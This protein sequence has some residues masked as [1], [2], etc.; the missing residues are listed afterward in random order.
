MF[1]QLLHKRLVKWTSKLFIIV[2]YPGSEIRISISIFTYIKGKV[3]YTQFYKIM[4]YVIN[5]GT[6][7]SFKR[8]SKVQKIIILRFPAFPQKTVIIPVTWNY[9][10]SVN[11]VNLVCATTTTALTKA[12]ENQWLAS[13]QLVS[14]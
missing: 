12:K 6:K 3:Q 9:Q 14:K 11:S 5:E 2:Q 7:H 1:S 4:F 8:E 13:C 10:P